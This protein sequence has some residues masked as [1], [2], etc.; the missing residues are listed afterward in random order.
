MN[1]K[2]LAELLPVGSFFKVNPH[3]GSAKGSQAVRYWLTEIADAS[4]DPRDRPVGPDT[5]ELQDTGLDYIRLVQTSVEGTPGH[6]PI[7]LP[8]VACAFLSV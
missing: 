2:R 4:V 3:P 8:L 6:P 1:D 5:F 7:L